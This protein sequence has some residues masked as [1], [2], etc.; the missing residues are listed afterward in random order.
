VK[1]SNCD[2]EI[3]RAEN[4]TPVNK[5]WLNKQSGIP[6]DFKKCWRESKNPDKWKPSNED[7]TNDYTSYNKRM[8]EYPEGILRHYKRLKEIGY[9]DIAPCVCPMQPNGVKGEMFL[10]NENGRRVRITKCMCGGCNCHDIV[11]NDTERAEQ[12]K[13]EKEEWMKNWGP[14]SSLYKKQTKEEII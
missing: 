4:W 9:C 5:I 6:H 11:Y 10:R 3:E 1:C 8:H 2:I 14:N 13:K 7:S 12:W